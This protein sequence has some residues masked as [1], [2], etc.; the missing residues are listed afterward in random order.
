MTDF[1]CNTDIRDVTEKDLPAY[2]YGLS[3]ISPQSL[4][5]FMNL[6]KNGRL[7][8]EDF[9]AASPEYD[10]PYLTP[11]GH[12][13]T[14]KDGD[15]FARYEV[16]QLNGGD[17][18]YLAGNWRISWTGVGTMQMEG[19]KTDGSFIT[20][21]SLVA[22]SSGTGS[23]YIK[24]SNIDPLDPLDNLEVV[25]EGDITA[26]DAGARWRQDSLT[27]NAKTMGCRFMDW[28]AVNADASVSITEK[29]PQEFLSQTPQVSIEDCV[30]YANA[31]YAA[32][33]KCNQPWFHIPR[34]A[35]AEYTTFIA[36][37]VRDNLT[38]GQVPRW[39]WGNEVFN[40]SFPIGQKCYNYALDNWQGSTIANQRFSVG[41]KFSTTAMKIITSVYG[42]R[43]DY[44]R[45]LG[46]WIKMNASYAEF[47]YD[48]T[49]WQINEPADYADPKLWH[50]ELNSSTYFGGLIK[51]DLGI[52]TAYEAA[53]ATTPG[54]GQA[55]A[56]SF[57]NSIMQPLLD[58]NLTYYQYFKDH[59]TTSGLDWV[60]YEC[61]HHVDTQVNYAD[62]M[63][64]TEDGT[65]ELKDWVVTTILAFIFENP[66]MADF[67]DENRNNA[68]S[69]GLQAAYRFQDFGNSTATWA[70]Q[71][72]VGDNNPTY[73]S[74]ANWLEDPANRQNWV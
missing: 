60:A 39:E 46:G 68:R 48:A 55:A 21:G 6:A 56:I 35:D 45:V 44:K 29:H 7:R 19:N 67:Q 3:A 74:F 25:H 34:N 14:L 41:A 10:S 18:D 42:N 51:Q 70:T 62:N 59:M 50:D 13:K 5:R 15:T 12:W 47:L 11:T 72:F 64:V 54:T 32:N 53:E 9:G 4:H 1:T 22:I 2:G 27:E 65:G 28:Q 17:L 23:V 37:Y 24:V 31:C 20:S 33:P 66:S 71:R 30:S 49:P 73:V 26:Y 61:N 63:Y 43:K 52:A 57:M 8:F 36:T 40:F 69:F 38:I 16:L 58:E